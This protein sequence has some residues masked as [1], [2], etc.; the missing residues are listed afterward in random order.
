MFAYESHYCSADRPVNPTALAC[1][2]TSSGVRVFDIRDPL[3]VKEIAYYVPPARPATPLTAWNSPHT[4]SAVIGV[5]ALSAPSIRD[6]LR[7]GEFDPAQAQSSR[8]GLLVSDMSSDM[9]FSPPEWRGN[10]LYVTCSDNGFQVIELTNA[11][12]RA[13]A[14]QETTV[15]S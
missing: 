12:Y 11:V 6:A 8:N 3:H 13:P 7:R 10:K 4:M 5:P 14:N 2:W 15:G 1:G 9:C